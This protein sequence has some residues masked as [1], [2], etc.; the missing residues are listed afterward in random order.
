MKNYKKQK[1]NYRPQRGLSEERW[2]DAYDAMQTD[3]PMDWIN[4]E[5]AEEFTEDFE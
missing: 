3:E 1:W 2:A 4:D 5:S